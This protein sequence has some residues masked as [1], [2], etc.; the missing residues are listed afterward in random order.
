MFCLSLQAFGT[1]FRAIP[2]RRRIKADESE[3]RGPTSQLVQSCFQLFRFDIN[4]L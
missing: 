2:V 3:A 1:F 4:D